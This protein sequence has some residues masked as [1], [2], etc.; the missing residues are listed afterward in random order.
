MY[1]PVI[2]FAL[3]ILVIGFLLGGLVGKAL[4]HLVTM[5]RV[6]KMLEKLGAMETFRRIGMNWNSGRVIG[7]LVKWFIIIVFLITALDMLG[8][9]EVNLFLRQIVLVYVPSVIIA[10]IILVAGSVVADW[11]SRAMRRASQMADMHAANFA[12]SVVKWAIWIFTLMV[13]FTQL[14]IAQSFI[15]TLFV[16]VVAMLALAG[17]LA[18]GLGGRDHASR[19]LD[20]VSKMVKRD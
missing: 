9:S 8:L 14:G 12:S 3:I 13:V 19:V 5:A 4:A 16:G 20:G 10:A 6:D 11:A 15:Q 17:G 2:I 7:G 18:F 1:L